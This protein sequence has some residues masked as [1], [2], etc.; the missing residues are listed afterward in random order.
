MSLFQDIFEHLEHP[1]M[2]KSQSLQVELGRLSCV[3]VSFHK[4]VSKKRTEKSW[5]S[6]I[7]C[8]DTWGNSCSKDP[9]RGHLFPLDCFILDV[10]AR[11][12]LI[13]PPYQRQ[14]PSLGTPNNFRQFA[15]HCMW[16]VACERTWLNS[17]SLWRS[18][19]SCSIELMAHLCLSCNTALR[20]NDRDSLKHRRPLYVW[21]QRYSSHRSDTLPCS[22]RLLTFFSF[23]N[24]LWIA[25]L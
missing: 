24:R 3:A 9:G 2:T 6:W 15:R 17:I 8:T 7:L 18:N 20:C 12:R 14:W 10:E 11:Q 21:G 5:T 1:S 23:A 13:W 19:P 22:E 25:N 16:M 4:L